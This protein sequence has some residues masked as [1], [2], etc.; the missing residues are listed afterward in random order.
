MSLRAGERAAEC[1]TLIKGCNNRV[2]LSTIELDYQA[3]FGA[4]SLA[5]TRC[6]FSKVLTRGSL[7]SF[8]CG[9]RFETITETRTRDGAHEL[10]VAGGVGGGGSLEKTSQLPEQSAEVTGQLV[11]VGVSSWR[12]KLTVMIENHSQLRILRASPFLC[13]LMQC[14]EQELTGMPL[15]VSSRIML[16]IA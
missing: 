6:S 8:G 5:F 11:D 16:T 1:S 13:Q 7:S 9:C 12:G 15:M 4:F 2:S 10:S 3:L 14:C